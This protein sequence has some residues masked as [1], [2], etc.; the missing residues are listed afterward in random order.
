[1]IRR[2]GRVKKVATS[3][4]SSVEKMIQDVAET[5]NL[6]TYDMIVQTTVVDEEAVNTQATHIKLDSLKMT[7]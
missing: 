3:R 1:M 4:R 7:V 2:R 6:A 5:S